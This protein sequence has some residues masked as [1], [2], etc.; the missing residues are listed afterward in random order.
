MEHFQRQYRLRVDI[1]PPLD[2][3]RH[4]ISTPRAYTLGDLIR[5]IES[6]LRIRRRQRLMIK[7][8]AMATLIGTFA[9]TMILYHFA[10]LI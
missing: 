6:R 4:L 8:L 3:I 10:G 7:T 2:E 1:P 9:G 5:D